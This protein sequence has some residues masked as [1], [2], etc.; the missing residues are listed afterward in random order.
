MDFKPECVEAAEI[1]DAN[2]LRLARLIVAGM[3]REVP[4]DIDIQLS[5]AHHMLKIVS[6][7][8]FNRETRVR[9]IV[10]WTNEPGVVEEISIYLKQSCSKFI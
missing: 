8:D 1:V 3:A 9:N 7:G 2:G 5:A 4:E 6:E 10:N